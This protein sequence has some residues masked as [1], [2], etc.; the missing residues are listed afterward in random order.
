MILNDIK[1]GFSELIANGSFTHAMTLKPNSTKLAA[2][3]P[4]F[5]ITSSNEKFQL[6]AANSSIQRTQNIPNFNFYDKILFDKLYKFHGL[7]DSKI[8]A[9]RFHQL[10]YTHLR[11][12]II[13]IAEGN[14]DTGHLHCAI[15]VHE[16]RIPKFD[17]IF[18]A[19]IANAEGKQLWNKVCVGGTLD[20]QKMD[21]SDRWAKYMTKS[22]FGSQCS[23]RIR[24][25]PE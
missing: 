12:Q 8:V 16:T 10:K 15:R 19:N 7:I 17:T 23:D 14:A 21:T 25:L 11:T 13:A 18:P 2:A 1:S 3:G 20:V 22:M 4:T 24:I 5:R 9:N 6:T